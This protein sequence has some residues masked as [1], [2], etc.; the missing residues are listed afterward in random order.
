MRVD[1]EQVQARTMSLPE[2]NVHNQ[3]LHAQLL[4]EERSRLSAADAGKQ[5]LAVT[6]PGE[7]WP[8]RRGFRDLL[9]Y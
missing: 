1:A 9:L 6:Q 8:A 5:P 2:R 3:K 7:L 4:D